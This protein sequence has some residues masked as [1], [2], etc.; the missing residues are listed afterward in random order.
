MPELV[1]DGMYKTKRAEL[2]YYYLYIG[3]LF[4]VVIFS[5]PIITIPLNA[6]RHQAMAQTLKNVMNNNNTN[7]SSAGVRSLSVSPSTTNVANISKAAPTNVT[8][9]NPK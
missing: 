9:T 1:K 6:H 8:R 2:G 7:L 5:L 3:I 4:A